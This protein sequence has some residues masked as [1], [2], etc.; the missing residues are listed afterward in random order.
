MTKS[1]YKSE[2][3]KVRNLK[4]TPD[5]NYSTIL[6][7]YQR[8]PTAFQKYVKKKMKKMEYN[9]ILFSFFYIAYT[10]FWV[11]YSHTQSEILVLCQNSQR[12]QYCISAGWH[13][14]RYNTYCVSGSTYSALLVFRLEFRLCY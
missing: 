4:F 7:K 13:V 3:I 11:E 8:N 9:L 14:R 10:R 6:V 2:N 12:A 5:V 1:F